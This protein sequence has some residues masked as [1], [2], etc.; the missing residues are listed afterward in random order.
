M[1][2][3]K[4]NKSQAGGADSAPTAA[5]NRTSPVVVRYHHEAVEEL[6][7]IK[8]Q[9]QRRAILTVVSHLFQLGD[10]LVM[11]HSR[12]VSGTKKLRELRPSGGQSVLRPL[13]API[14]DEY[15]V[16]TIGPEADTDPQGF[17]R[18]VERAQRRAKA[19]HGIEL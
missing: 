6:A 10:R 14:D 5:P 12:P 8:D 15:V 1:A 3:S 2:R 16:L 18:A 17:R 13:Y 11:P 19:D 9:K 4:K 7:G